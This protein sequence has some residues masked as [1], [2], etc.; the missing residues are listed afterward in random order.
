MSFQI[1][2]GRLIVRD[3]QEDDIPNLV[4]QFAEPEARQNI[5]S[6]QAD[7]I[8]NKNE[9]EKAMAWARE[10]RRPYYK[11]SVELK[12][13]GDLIGCCNLSD[14]ERDGFETS[15]GWHYGHRFRGNGYA[16]E[17]ARAMLDFAFEFV[18]VNEVFADCFTGNLA[19]IRIIE[20]I[21]MSSTLNSGLFNIIR[22]WSYGENKP[23][24]R[25]TISRHEWREQI[26]HLRRDG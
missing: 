25:H 10:R 4:K 23:T 13:G 6:F 15:L 22:G 5:L 24:I 17:V 16:T 1:E 11:L 2:T 3:V 26:K 8:Y 14:A 19:S 18:E 7:E 20:K 12:G 9:L 21:G